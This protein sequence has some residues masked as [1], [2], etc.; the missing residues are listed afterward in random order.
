MIINI[1][2]SFDVQFPFYSKNGPFYYYGRGE[3]DVIAVL[4]RDSGLHSIDRNN[5]VPAQS[6]TDG[7]EASTKQ[8]FQ[9]AFGKAVKSFEV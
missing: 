9:T 7:C 5:Y 2:K 8:E 4:L 6:V 3:N 1:S